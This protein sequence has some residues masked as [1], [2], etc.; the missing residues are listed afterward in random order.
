MKIRSYQSLVEHGQVRTLIDN[1]EKV[2][3]GKRR[4]VELSVVALLCGG[5]VLLEDV[6]GVGKTMMVRAIAKSIGA[7]FKRIQ[8]TPDLLPSDVT[9]VSVFNQKD[10]EFHFRPGPVM[11][12][13][14]L[15][16]EINRTSPKTQA[17]LL[18]AL[19]EGSV[20]VDGETRTLQDPF[21]VMATQNPIE[22]SGTYP[23]PEAQLDRFLFKFKIGYPTKTEELDV[24]NRVERQ[25]P[26]ESLS[27][28]LS[29][30][31]VV[32]IKKEVQQV[33]VHQSV[34]HYIIDLVTS[35]RLHHAVSLGASPRASISLMKAAQ[36]L[37]LM[38]GRNYTVPD[39]VKFLAP[40][41]LQHRMI[42]TSDAKLSN[43]SNERIVADVIEQVRVPAGEEIGG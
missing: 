41:V 3:V 43:Q 17:A 27:E 31:D 38:Q 18:E 10:M 22:Y 15:A 7:E 20:T 21:L 29:L 14:V 25:H 6:P 19:E 16:D 11:S 30:Q 37:A 2:V 9:G 24:L 8:F 4:E 39:D 12:N 13:I 33:K 32:N 42:L 5:H 28:V 40:Y 34:K 26:I 1:V 36:A 35:T 23:L